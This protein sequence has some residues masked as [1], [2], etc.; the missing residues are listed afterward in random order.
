MYK[1]VFL[2]HFRL[3]RGQVSGSDGLGYTS[4]VVLASETGNA[5]IAKTAEQKEHAKNSRCGDAKVVVRMSYG[6]RSTY[7]AVLS[8]NTL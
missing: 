6:D 2:T 1:K 5:K 3:F 4:A 7:A 8:C